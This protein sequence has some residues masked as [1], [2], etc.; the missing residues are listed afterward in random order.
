MDAVIRQFESYLPASLVRFR[1][2]LK[3]VLRALGDARDLDIALME[4]EVFSRDLSESDQ[5]TSHALREHLRAERT[6]A[7]ERMM[8]V[9]DL[10]AVQK[11]FEKLTATLAEPPA[12]AGEPGTVT[13]FSA[14]Q[15]IPILIR[16]RYKKVRKDANRLK[17]DSSMD[18]YHAVRGRAKKFRYALESVADILGKPANDMIRSLRRWQ[19][20]LGV[21]QDADVAGRRLQALAANPPASLPPETLFLMGRLAAHHNRVAAKARKRHPRAYRKVRARWKAL[22]SRL[23]ELTPVESKQETAASGP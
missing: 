16:A 7:R 3:K 21:Q 12:A 13:P 1:P 23:E 22:K 18:D 2:T 20:K 4:L 9:L 11:E 17:P 19:E 8:S 14:L 6:T 15:A 10:A 5:A